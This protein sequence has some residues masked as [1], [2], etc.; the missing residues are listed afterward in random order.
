MPLRCGNVAEADERERHGGRVVDE[1]A[2][3]DLANYWQPTHPLA[4]NSPITISLYL[5]QILLIGLKMDPLE[6]LG[7]WRGNANAVLNFLLLPKVPPLSPPPCPLSLSL[8]HLSILP[9]SLVFPPIC[10][11]VSIIGIERRT[12]E[13]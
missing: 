6:L 11:L 3:A 4:P 8:S 10:C 9:H 12:V 2:A 1:A 7:G 5:I 13:F